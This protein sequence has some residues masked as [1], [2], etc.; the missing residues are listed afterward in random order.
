MFQMSMKVAYDFITRYLMC[1][2]AGNLIECL[3]FLSDWLLPPPATAYGDPHAGAEHGV[4]LRDVEGADLE[5]WRKR[6]P[7]L[8]NPSRRSCSIERIC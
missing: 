7:V 1:G 3:K 6:E 4:Y 8:R 2:G 5:D